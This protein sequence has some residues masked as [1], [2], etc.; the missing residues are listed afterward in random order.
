[1]RLFKQVT[2]R[3]LGMD[4]KIQSGDFHS[5]DDGKVLFTIKSPETI[6]Q[7]PKDFSP[8]RSWW[9]IEK[10]EKMRSW[11]SLGVG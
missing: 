4:E 3:K 10:M 6:G 2:F 5:L 1:M 9:T 7:T 11:Q 8:E